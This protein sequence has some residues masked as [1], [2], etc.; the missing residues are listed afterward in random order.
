VGQANDRVCGGLGLVWLLGALQSCTD[1]VCC[2]DCLL[3]RSCHVLAVCFL[4]SDF[5]G[6]RC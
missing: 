2:A 1:K 3:L 6:K 5:C 4:L